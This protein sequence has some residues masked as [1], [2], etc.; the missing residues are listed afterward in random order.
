MLRKIEQYKSRYCYVLGLS[1]YLN[2][3]IDLTGLPAAH[4][5]KTKVKI[6][7]PVLKKVTVHAQRKKRRS[8]FL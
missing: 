4:L 7:C 1:V 5:M 2:C 3:I 8:G 6:V